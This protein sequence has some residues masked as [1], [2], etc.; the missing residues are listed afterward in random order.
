MRFRALRRQPRSVR[1]ALLPGRDPVHHFRSGDCL[2]I[3]LGR[4]LESYRG[5][6]PGCHGPVP[7]HPADRLCLWME[8]GSAGMGLAAADTENFAQRG[9]LTTRVD[10][11]VS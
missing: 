1:R 3:S 6:W 7:V 4:V 10:S 8:E 5:A 2:S 9:F 11:L